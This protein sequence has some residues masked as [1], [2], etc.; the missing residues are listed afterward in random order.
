MCPSARSIVAAQLL[1]AAAA[2]AAAVAIYNRFAW[3]QLQRL[4]NADVCLSRE[5]TAQY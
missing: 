2:A 5:Y 4:P 3:R 1:A